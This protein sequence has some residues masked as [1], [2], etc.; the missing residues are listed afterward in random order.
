VSTGNDLDGEVE[1]LAQVLDTTVSQV[2]VV[3]LPGETDRDKTT[4]L[5]RLESLDDV[6]VRDI[7]VT[8]LGSV[9]V[10]LSNKD[11]LLEEVPIHN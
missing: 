9:E 4:G 1:V 3:V 5:Q 7:D 6:Q 11:T 8:V 2:V 10:L